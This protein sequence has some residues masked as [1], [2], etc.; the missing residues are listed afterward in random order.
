MKIGI[1]TACFYPALTEQAV[2]YLAVEEVDCVEV[3]LNSWTEL[4]PA[5]LQTLKQKLQTIPVV[6]VH[7]F[8][9]EMENMLFF[10]EYERRREEGLSLYSKFFQACQQLNARYFIFHG[11]TRKMSLSKELYLKRLIPLLDVAERYGVTVLQ[12]NVARCYSGQPEFLNYLHERLE[13]RLGF[14]LDL[15]Q[16]VRAGV[17]AFEMQKAMGEQL[18]HI[19][20]SDCNETQDCLPPGEG[21]FLFA[22]FLQQVSRR[23]TACKTAV[24][25]LYQNNYRNRQ[26]LFS[27]YQG[28]RNTFGD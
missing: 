8:T 6:A 5:Y 7:P 16:C 4:Q 15:K 11:A 13:N 17:S 24:I 3:F 25:E 2:E 19:H 1:S 27:A 23:S 20:I 12:E 10:S 14:V 9:S 21:S 22:D 18:F 26:Q 28:F